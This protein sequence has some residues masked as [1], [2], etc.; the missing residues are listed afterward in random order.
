MRFKKSS[1]ERQ[2]LMIV[3]LGLLL[4]TAGIARLAWW[5]Q[6]KAIEDR[7]HSLSANEMQSLDAL[8]NAAML[9]RLSDS[10]NVALNV[11]DGWFAQRNADY[12]GA[13]WSAW[14]T[15]MAEVVAKTDPQKKIKRTRDT[16]D[17]E[18]IRTKAP[19]ARFVG[20]TYRFST[21]V[22]LGGTKATAR[23]ECYA[24]HAAPMGQNKGDVIAV[25]SSS[26]SAKKDLAERDQNVKMLVMGAVS[27]SLLLL[28]AIKL[29]FK[30]V[31]ARPLER[32]IRAM[33]A[34]AGRDTS[35]E[36]PHLNR[37]DEIGQTARAVQ[38][39][40][41]SMIETQRLT[42]QEKAE[43]AAKV[44]RA[45][46][47]EDLTQKFQASTG[48]MVE[49]LSE[50]ASE[51]K[52]AA[53]AMHDTA[54]KASRHSLSV[55]EAIDTA[56]ENVNAVAASTE[57][58]TASID[59]IRSHVKQAATIAGR[60]VNE[61]QQTDS[62]VQT[63]SSAAAKISNIVEMIGTI[64]NQTNLLALNAGVEAARAGDAGRGFAV[65]AAEV[66]LLANKTAEA[67]REI[68]TEIRQ[69][70]EWSGQAVTAINSVG[71]TIREISDIA[72]AID[73]EVEQQRLATQAIAKNAQDTAHK[74][75]E[76]SRN[77]NTVRAASEETGEVS[78]QVLGSAGHLAEQSDQLSAD[79]N[80]FIKQIGAA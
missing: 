43:Q 38:V 23:A 76:V 4:A 80:S 46:H 11:F 70:Q 45:Q 13:L 31:V 42:Q 29:T 12:P 2:F 41:E 55:A 14:N 19:V 22:I 60:A 25:F 59:G 78:E 68:A 32:M 27:F 15:P 33:T 21:P 63:L 47:L 1:L 64:A 37:S 17:E 8:V 73:G 62:I 75:S 49:Q 50:A 39:F 35:Y 69:I 56:S 36:V 40:K 71:G 65:V 57:Q 44:K 9:A 3:G 7:L 10:N 79:V 51:L 5:S 72:S 18:V 52:T 26:L 54:E 53:K 61:A 77:I 28:I 67:T 48:S 16:I 58:L 30:T 24:C 66:K 34:L 6:T 20:D 74:T